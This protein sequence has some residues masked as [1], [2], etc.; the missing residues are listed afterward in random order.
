MI[1]RKISLFA[2]ASCLVT[3]VVPSVASADPG[4]DFQLCTATGTGSAPNAVVCVD[5]T[6]T[7]TQNVLTGGNGGVA[8]GNAGGLSQRG[9][10][11]LAVNPASGNATRFHVRRGRLEDPDL[12]P[13]GGTPVSGAL[14]KGAYVLTTTKLV[15][16]PEHG[17]TPDGSRSLRLGDGSAAQV[18]VT[19]EYAYVSEKNGSLEAFRLGE[20]GSLVSDATAVAGITPGVIVGIAADDDVVVAP[21][22][23]LASNPG[24]SEIDVA[25]GL[26]T[27]QTVST[28]QVAACWADADDREVCI[29]NPGSHTISCGALGGRALRQLNQVAAIDSSVSQFDIAVRDSLVGVLVR[30]A[31]GVWSLQSYELG[32]GHQ[33]SLINEAPVGSTTANGAVL[34]KAFR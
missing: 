1:M 14:G 16:F 8:G 5:Q 27:V 7:V 20:D 19:E 13:T 9:D 3:T 26:G 4:R 22:A 29:T 23:H 12:L 18:V 28:A 31:R 24:Q 25:D 6:G 17:V 21:I 32:S 10:H 33:L 15:H 11:V 34:L 30:S 2:I